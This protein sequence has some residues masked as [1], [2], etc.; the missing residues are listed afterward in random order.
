MEREGEAAVTEEKVLTTHH[1]PVHLPPVLHHVVKEIRIEVTTG[2]GNLPREIP[3][4][5]PRSLVATLDLVTMG[6]DHPGVHQGP[7]VGVSLPALGAG[8]LAT[9]PC[10]VVSGT[11]TDHGRKRNDLKAEVVT[12]VETRG[13]APGLRVWLHHHSPQMTP[14]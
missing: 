2:A 10:A 8:L 5:T 12:Q 4:V 3:T 7:R 6:G 13:E 14:T 1:L 9:T 11:Q